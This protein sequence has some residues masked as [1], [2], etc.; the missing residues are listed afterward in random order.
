M[1]RDIIIAALVALVAVVWLVQ[2]IEQREPDASS[3]SGTALLN[4]AP[5]AFKRVTGPEPLVF[6]ADHAMHP[7]FRNEWWYFT[8]NLSDAAGR[9]YGFQ[10]TLFRF[11]VAPGEPLDSD[12]DSDAIWMAHFAIS[13]VARKRFISEERFAR[14]ALDLAGATA[15]EWWLR[16]WTVTRTED[17]WRLRAQLDDASLDLD[18]APRKPVVLQGDSG[19][20]QKGP[21]QGN[22]SRYY[23]ITRIEA[24]GRLVLDGNAADVTGS[25]WLDREWGSSQLGPGIAGWDWFALQLK[26]GRDLMLY[27]LRTEGGEASRFSAGVLVEADGG[28]RVLGREDFAFEE[29]R[30]WEDRQGVDWPVAWRVLLPAEGMEF[31][32]RPAFDAQRWYATVG[33]WEGAVDVIDPVDQRTLGR[34][35]LE[36]SGYADSGDGPERVGVR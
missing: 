3:V 9:R 11:A 32:V 19:Y 12:F 17:G 1:K 22:A 20:S 15:D 8:G 24:D 36:L 34:G 18:L 13:D 33:Y 35:Y 31:E 10:F 14:G 16:D 5:D 25:A 26:D 23:S 21:A 30:R 4:A 6:P 7:G 29:I 27:R 2:R 28:Y